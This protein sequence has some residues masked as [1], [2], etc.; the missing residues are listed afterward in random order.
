[1]ITNYKKARVLFIGDDRPHTRSYYWKLAMMDLCGQVDTV[2]LA[3]DFRKCYPLEKLMARFANK[4]K[5]PQDLLQ[6]NKRAL[7]FSK[8]N[9]YDIVWV[10]KGHAV[11]GRTILKIKEE[12]KN[13]RVAFYSEDDMLAKH[14][15]DRYFQQTLPYY[16]VVFTTKSYNCRPNE[17]P[18]LGAKKVIMVDKAYSKEL[19][20][21]MEVT[22][23]DKNKFGA[24]VGFIGSFEE[25][26]A[27]KMLYLAKQ[28]IQ[29]RIWGMGWPPKW[30]R[31]HSNLLIEAKP[32][33]GKDYVK[34]ICSTDINLCFLRKINRD[35]QTDRTMEIPACGGFMLAE[36]TDEHL[37]LFEEGKEAEFFDSNAELLQKVKYYLAHE[38]HR[39]RIAGEGKIRCEMAKYD[40]NSRLE[41]MLGV[42]FSDT[43]AMPIR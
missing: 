37:R 28:G 32:L 34:G 7:D 1:M 27:D 19:H 10:L 13:A 35:L 8:K 20:R 29:V 36:R 39:G 11:R 22:V 31:R 6:I 12:Q 18:S 3:D 41:Y 2:S 21:P 30:Q 14:N 24:K 4:M 38:E 25:N 17:L 23:S 40:M 26:R 15:C 5:Y 16:D 42:L 9:K 33:L 43:G